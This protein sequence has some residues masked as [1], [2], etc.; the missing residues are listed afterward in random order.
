MP[1]EHLTTWS[2]VALKG[3][4]LIGTEVI[5]LNGRRL[6]LKSAKQVSVIKPWWQKPIFQTL[7]QVSLA[8]DEV[9]TVPLEEMKDKFLGTLTA[10]GWNYQIDNFKDLTLRVRNATSISELASILAP[11]S[12]L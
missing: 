9:G 4:A 7:V 11:L 1:K 10:S 2:K 3:G 5:D 12:Q 6:R 8:F